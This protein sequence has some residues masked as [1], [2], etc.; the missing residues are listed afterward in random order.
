MDEGKSRS[1][2]CRHTQFIILPKSCPCS[3]FE[4]AMS[5]VDKAFVGAD[6]R[7][8]CGF[9]ISIVWLLFEKVENADSKFCSSGTEE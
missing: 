1:R 4:S 7:I 3:R 5:D 8:R 6:K 9:C 2:P